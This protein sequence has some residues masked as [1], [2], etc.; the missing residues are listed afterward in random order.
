[1]SIIA[2]ILGIVGLLLSCVL[3]GIIPCSIGLA[4]SIISLKNQKSHKDMAIIGL[5]TSSVGILIFVLMMVFV[6]K[7]VDTVN[8]TENENALIETDFVKNEDKNNSTVELEKEE[9]AQFIAE[10]ET[11]VNEP[12]TEPVTIINESI[13]KVQIEI[14]AEDSNE[15]E[16]ILQIFSDEDSAEEIETIEQASNDKYFLNNFICAYNAIAEHKID[17]VTIDEI[18]KSKRPLSRL[19]Y[20]YTNRVYTIFTYNEG[21]NI[22]IDIQYEGTSD[23]A[24]YPIFRDIIKIMN[25]SLLD[26]EIDETWYNL[27][28]QK[29]SNYNEYDLNGINCTYS[30][31]TL[32]NG[33]NRYYIKAWINF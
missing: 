9:T 29:Y 18:D 33:E 12:E 31:Q 32:V 13:K 21:Y 19:T 4:L 28:S 22:F 27:Q 1:M 5:V 24:I 16:S 15:I 3:I 14:G 20:T 10:T 26:Q 25:P 6:I 30:I 7:N 8:K 11:F 23:E 17:E 2:L